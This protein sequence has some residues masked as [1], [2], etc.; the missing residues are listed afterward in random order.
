MINSCLANSA[1]SNGLHIHNYTHLI[2]SAINECLQVHTLSKQLLHNIMKASEDEKVPFTYF[3]ESFQGC[4][5][6]Y[7][8]RKWCNFGRFKTFLW[9]GITMHPKQKSLCFYIPSALYRQGYFEHPERYHVTVFEFLEIKLF[10]GQNKDDIRM[11]CFGRNKICE[12]AQQDG[13]KK[14]TQNV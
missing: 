13:R 3:N 9:R 6:R 4:T 2:A 11:A 8:Y 10:I 7:N 12:F 5:L 14:R 1:L